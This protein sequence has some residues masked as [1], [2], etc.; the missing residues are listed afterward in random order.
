MTD[1]RPLELVACSLLRNIEYG[2]KLFTTLYIKHDNNRVIAL[3]KQTFLAVVSVGIF[4][5][6]DHQ[7]NGN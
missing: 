5:V 7:L 4:W 3:S 1:Q 6:F 2:F